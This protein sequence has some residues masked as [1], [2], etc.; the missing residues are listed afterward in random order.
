MSYARTLYLTGDRKQAQ[1]ELH[2]VVSSTP[3]NALAWFLLGVLAEED[4]DRDSAVQ[5]YRAA[6]HAE[7][8][9][10]GAEFYLGNDSYRHGRYDAAAAHYAVSVAAAPD[11]LPVY[12][13]YAGALLHTRDGNAQARAMID[14]ARKRFP[15]DPLLGF[16]QLQLQ[17]LSGDRELARAALARARAQE[18]RQASPPNRELL[19]LALAA[20]GD[21]KQAATMQD[22]LVTEAA[23]GMPT[24]AERLGR[25]L[26]DYRAGRLPAQQDLLTWQLLQPPRAQGRSVFLD[27]P[28]PRPY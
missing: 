20:T 12:L 24:A 9:H 23:W 26:A 18:Q 13:P 22:A 27:Y 28:A 10:G 21:F 25:V 17:A 4:G 11:N 6:L 2:T 19:A 16:V 8:G 14:L 7:P 3:S 1:R 15:E 5:D